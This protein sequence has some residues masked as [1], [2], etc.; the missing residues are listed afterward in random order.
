MSAIAL[1]AG[2][3]LMYILAK[4]LVQAPGKSDRELEHNRVGH[5]AYLGEQEGLRKV[6]ENSRSR[7]KRKYRNQTTNHKPTEL[8]AKKKRPKK[9]HVGI[10]GS[11]PFF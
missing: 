3:G 5:L 1:I 11:L 10:F 9:P 8:K 6:H 2:G 4:N 7:N